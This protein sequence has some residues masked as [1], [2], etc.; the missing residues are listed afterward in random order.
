M[1]YALARAVND[2]DFIDDVTTRVDT[3]DGDDEEE[4]EG[5]IDEGEEGNVE[6]GDVIM[7]G[8]TPGHEHISLYAISHNFNT[9]LC[10]SDRYYGWA[11]ETE[12]RERERERGRDKASK[13]RWLNKAFG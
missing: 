11:H 5:D 2:D 9:C 6:E 4:E 7:A 1:L 12:K 10:S 3:C 13:V 8:A